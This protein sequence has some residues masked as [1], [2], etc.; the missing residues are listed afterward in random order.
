MEKE[1]AFIIL[2]AGKGTRLGGTIPKPL[3]E[4]SDGRTILQQQ[5]ENIAAVFGEKAWKRTFVVVGHKA[6]LVVDVLPKQVRAIYNENYDQT[7]T[8]KS[9]LRA[10]R[11]SEKYLGA[12]WFN[13]DVVFSPY[14]LG[15]ALDL[16]NA[17]KS[18]MVVTN[19]SV[20]E[21]EMKYSLDDKGLISR[22]S[23]T[24]MNGLGEAVGINFVSALD[25]PS[26][27]EALQKVPGDAYFEAA[28]QET[29]RKDMA[30][31]PL[32]TNGL[33]AVE[34]DFQEDLSRINKML[35]TV[36]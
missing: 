27:R 2:A 18:F 9:L 36:S 35:E 4:L 24:N 7:N 28:I 25:S 10:L 21:E 11:A 29:I 5:L 22:I 13:G 34:V 1:S 3:T 14:I 20:A 33:Y 31:L 23:K 16:M 30:W 32:S 26:F 19:D 15:R 17:Q 8:S 12:M 6:E